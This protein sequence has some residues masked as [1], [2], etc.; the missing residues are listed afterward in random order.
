MESGIHCP[1]GTETELSLTLLGQHDAVAG[2]A[3]PYFGGI[4]NPHFRR[5]KHNP[6]LVRQLPVKN[7]TLADGNT[8][9]VVSVYDLVLANYGLDRGLEDENSAKDYAEIKPYTPAW[10]S[11][12]P[13]CRASILKPSPVN[14]P[15]PPIKR[16]GVR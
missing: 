7:L 2:V 11:K 4:E 5:V 14:L 1:C 16:M 13:A 10:V 3:F 15:I 9:P 6:V 8:C 12:L